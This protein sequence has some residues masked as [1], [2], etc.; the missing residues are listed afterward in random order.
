MKKNCLSLQ[1]SPYYNFESISLS[2]AET[3]LF[4]RRVGCWKQPL[5]GKIIWTE[6]QPERGKGKDNNNS[7]NFVNKIILIFI[8]FLNFSVSFETFGT[9]IC[10]HSY[11]VS[12]NLGIEKID[13]LKLKEKNKWLIPIYMVLSKNVIELIFSILLHRV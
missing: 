1:K 8:V 10:L 5:A 6:V 13:S 2:D 3:V 12:H 4:W 7:N 11:F 9:Q